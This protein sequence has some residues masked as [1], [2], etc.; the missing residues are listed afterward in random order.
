VNLVDKLIEALEE[1]IFEAL[2]G[3]EKAGL[4]L[5]GGLD[6]AVI[7]AIAKLDNLYCATWPDQDNHS[8]AEL[9]AMGKPLTRVTFTKQQMLQTLPAVAKATNGS[10]TWSQV[11]QW[12]LAEAAGNDGCTLVFTG[13]CSDEL[14]CGYS[15]YRILWWLDK[16]RADPKLRDYQNTVDHCV[17]TPS[18]AVIKLLSR[19]MN[20]ALSERLVGKALDRDPSLIEHSFR[21][22]A[23]VEGSDPLSQLLENETAMIKAHDL[24]PCYPFLDSR[25]QLVGGQVPHDLQVN[26]YECKVLLRQVARKLGVHHFI[27]DEPSKKG[28][29]VPQSWRPEGEPMWSRNWFSKLIAEAYESV[30]P[31]K[32][33]PKL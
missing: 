27:C 7:Q 5:S 23:A 25:V 11:C 32:K 28:L 22:A 19:N 31:K 24:K 12:Y 33:F 29:F 1:V 15:R 9:A 3:Q 26:D 10:A 8:A 17:G 6:S 13:E 18:G 2:N 4:F 16:M 21:L 14:L 20:P 30:C